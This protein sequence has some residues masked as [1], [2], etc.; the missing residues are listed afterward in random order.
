MGSDFGAARE[1]ITPLQIGKNYA[2]RPFSCHSDGVILFFLC[3]IASA[4]FYLVR[5]GLKM[6]ATRKF[7]VFIFNLKDNFLLL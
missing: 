1:T 6:I 2:A 4:R 7:Y 3:S 5:A